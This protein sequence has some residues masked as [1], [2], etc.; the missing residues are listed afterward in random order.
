MTNYADT[1]EAMLRRT[2]NAIARLSKDRGWSPALTLLFLTVVDLLHRLTLSRCTG[3]ENWSL[4]EPLHAEDYTPSKIVR[5]YVRSLAKKFKSGALPRSF[6]D[7]QINRAR[8][9]AIKL[10]D[11]VYEVLDSRL[12]HVLDKAS[13]VSSYEDLT[14]F[15][16]ELETLCE[17]GLAEVNKLKEQAPNLVSLV[18]SILRIKKPSEKA[19][20]RGEI[21]RDLDRA[22]A[23]VE[24]FALSAPLARAYLKFLE[25]A[26]LEGKDSEN[27]TVI[28]PKLVKIVNC[29]LKRLEK[30]SSASKTST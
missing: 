19:V 7:K 22:S 20:V 3:Y 5:R 4:S 1:V 21:Q 13:R 10:L 8:S 6:N 29:V 26:I 12:E 25:K 18:I 2:V 28:T 14:Q 24:A 16:G 11:E 23:C 30:V 15:V 17:R 9:R 27:I